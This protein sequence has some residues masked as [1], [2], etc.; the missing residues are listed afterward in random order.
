MIGAQFENPVAD[1]RKQLVFKEKVFTGSSA[2]PHVLRL[3][4]PLSIQINQVDQLIEKMRSVL[5][6]VSDKTPGYRPVSRVS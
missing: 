5:R 3:L 1:L 4:P 6:S 2:D